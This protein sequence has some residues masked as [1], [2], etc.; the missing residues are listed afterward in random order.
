MLY[1]N[2]IFSNLSIFNTHLNYLLPY[3]HRAL[4][5]FLLSSFSLLE[6]F[7]KSYLSVQS[8]LNVSVVLCYV[9]GGG[10]LLKDI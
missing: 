8:V 2:F 7:E 10:D 3:Q 4:F 5:S 6:L 1:M 9:P